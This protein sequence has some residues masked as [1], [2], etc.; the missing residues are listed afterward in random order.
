MQFP[1]RVIFQTLLLIVASFVTRA[2]SAEPATQPAIDPHCVRG[3][4][5]AY[6]DQLPAGGMKAALTAYH[7][8]NERERKLAKSLARADVAAAKLQELTHQKFG[9]KASDDV[10]HAMRLPTDTDLADA[11]EKIEG[12]RATIEWADGRDSLLMVKVNGKWEISVADLL[13]TDDKDDESR[14]GRHCQR[15]STGASRQAAAV[16]C[17]GRR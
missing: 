3:E 8:T 15:L 9:Q 14:G 10:V 13:D 1:R 12:D 6:G 11:T 7:A 16:S 4:L 5:K 17:P 2:A